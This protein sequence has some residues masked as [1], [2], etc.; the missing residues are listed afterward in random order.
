MH[1][2]GQLGDTCNTHFDHS[3]LT[4][5]MASRA[6]N[7]GLLRKDLLHLMQKESAEH[8]ETLSKGSQRPE[9]IQTRENCHRGIR[10]QVLLLDAHTCTSVSRAPA[11][12]SD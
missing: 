5:R 3:Y 8:I 11:T 6:S 7:G 2:L 4:P 10:M 9:L 1:R 12:H